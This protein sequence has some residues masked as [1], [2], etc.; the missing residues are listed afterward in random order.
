[1]P[2]TSPPE[3]TGSSELSGETTE[4][5]ARLAEADAPPVPAPGGG[6][7]ALIVGGLILALI[8]GFGLGRLNTDSGGSASAPGVSSDHTHAPGT[9][10]HEHGPGATTTGTTPVGTELGGLSLSAAGFTL[11]PATS[12]FRAGQSQ[13]FQFQVLGADRKPVTNFTVVH[14]KPLHMIVARRDLSGYQHLHPTMA[15]DGTWS[16][17]LTLATPG[18]WRAYADFTA[19]DATGKQTAVTLGVDL[20]VNG[21]YAPRALP[22]AAREATVGEFTVTYEG[23]PQVGASAPLMFRVFANGSPVTDLERYLGAYGHLVAL[24]GGDLGYVHV[25]PEEQ[26]VGGA[27]KFWLAVPSPGSYRLFFDFQLAGVIRTA[28]FTLTVS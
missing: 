6:R 7:M 21:D 5:S 4:S 26:L 27:V 16:V 24:R 2:V 8:G 20:V 11:V 9:A 13:P 1:M 19:A 15:P 23:T 25:H 18:I 28:E 22:P 14:D 12:S 17:P 3:E 10:P